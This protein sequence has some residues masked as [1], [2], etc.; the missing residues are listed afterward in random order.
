MTTL[1]CFLADEDF[2][3]DILRGVRLRM[4][5]VDIVRAQDV[6]LSGS[7]DPDVLEWAAREGRVLLTHDVNS[8]IGHAVTR[9]QAGM[10]MPGVVAVRQSLLIGKAIEDILLLAQ[11]GR[12][13]DYEGQVE[14]LPL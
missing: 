6:G 9:V 2:D 5:E 8:M 4:P 10:R 14:Y 7:D 13:G 3:N 11:C 12:E 1:L